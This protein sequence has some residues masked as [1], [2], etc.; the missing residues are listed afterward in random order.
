[1]FPMD[2]EWR[3]YFLAYRAEFSAIF[4]RLVMPNSAILVAE[5]SI[6]TS[7]PL[8]YRFSEVID[9]TLACPVTFFWM[10]GKLGDS[11]YR[12]KL[13]DY[14]EFEPDY[15]SHLMRLWYFSSSVNSFFKRTYAAIQWGKMS[16]SWSDPSSTSILHVC[17]QRRLW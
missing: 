3:I 11:Q 9:S 6:C 10:L 2:L 12:H 1:M 8:I 13:F 5:F 4:I 7:Q 16:D 14:V 17:E 15:L